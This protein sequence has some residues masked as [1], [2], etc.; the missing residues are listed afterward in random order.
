MQGG[1]F[2]VEDR[3]VVMVAL[4]G[5]ANLRSMDIPCRLV[6][7]QSAAIPATISSMSAR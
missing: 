3:L 6:K 2:V 5:C 1:S 4:G 7:N